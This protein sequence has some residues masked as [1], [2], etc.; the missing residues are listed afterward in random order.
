MKALLLLLFLAGSSLC[1]Q[2]GI[3]TVSPTATLD[4]NGTMRLRTTSQISRE[5]AAKD[6]IMVS[7]SQGNIQRI[8]SKKVVQSH[9][10]SFV[11]GGFASSGSQNLNLVSGIVTVPFNAEDFDTNGEYSL[12]TNTFTATQAGIYS[13]SVQIKAVAGLSVATNFGIAIVKN[14][15]VVARSGFGNVS[16]LGITVSPPIRSVNTLQKLAV[17]DTISFQ[18]YSDLVSAGILGTK[19]D[20]FFWIAQEQ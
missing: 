3:N 15:V 14:G 6:S 20:S 19:E 1:A 16:V 9:L 7:D 12:S 10:K 17:D 18:L 2:I 4:V 13:I 8:S 11:K 5:T